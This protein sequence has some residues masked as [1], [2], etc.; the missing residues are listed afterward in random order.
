[1]VS[2]K[3]PITITI[4]DIPISSRIVPI[5][6]SRLGLPLISSMPLWIS[7]VYG[8]ALVPFP[9]AGIRPYRSAMVALRSVFGAT[10]C[11]LEARTT[12]H[13]LK[14]GATRHPAV[15]GRYSFFSLLRKKKAKIKNMNLAVSETCFILEVPVTRAW[16]STGISRM[17]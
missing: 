2:P 9:A 11:G 7:R 15:A 1:M 3:W 12:Y 8:R 6:R 13:R 4:S 17:A 16:K 14:A 5:T 10:A